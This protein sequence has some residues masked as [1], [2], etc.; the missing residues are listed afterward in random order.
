MRYQQSRW[1]L[2]DLFPGPNSAELEAAF[3]TL[4][5]QV[6]ALEKR[7]PELTDDISLETFLSI[8]KELETN[9]ELAQKVYAFAG[10][11]FAEDT[12]NQVALNLMAKVEQ[13]V[14]E[15]GN[16]ILFFNLWW[17]DLPAEKAKQLIDG[18]GDYAYW[19][20]AMRLFIPH[21]LSEAE[22]KIINIKNVTGQSALQMVYSS[23]TNRYV[24]KLEVDG[25]VKELTR[26]ELM[27]YVRKADPEIRA[28]AYQELYKVYGDDSPILGQIYQT[29]VR[30]WYNEQVALRKHAS[31]IAARNLI[32]D[33]PDAVVNTLLDVCQKNASV[34]QSFFRLKAKLIG[35]DKLRRYDIYAPVVKSDKTYP[36]EVGS[37]LVL[38]AYQAFDPKFAE[39]AERVFAQKHLDSEVRKGK[40]GGAFC[41][42]SGPDLTP[43]V[44]LNYQAKADDVSTMAHELG[45]A[46]HGMLAADHS[47]F[48]FHSNLPLAE[49]ASTFG[50]MVLV[51]HLL[52]HETDENVRRDILFG[53]ID[54]AYGTIMRQAF[55]A[56]FERKAHQMIQKGASVDDLAEAYLQNLKSQ[57][58][59]AVEVS[60]EFRWEWVSIPH[61]YDVPFYVYAYTFGQLLVLSLYQ[62]YKREGQSFIPRYTKIL[63]TGGSKAPVKVLSEAGI[64]VYDAS[65]WQGGFDVLKGLISELEAL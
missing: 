2:D 30:D 53:Q 58:G 62:Q 43:W 17:K 24:F 45:H 22:E 6:V 44:M 23:I 19:L 8:I 27:M 63:A 13:F 42:P 21:T 46:I 48:T 31:P 52:K 55:F 11:Y 29:L 4:G 59:D 7:R 39:L 61:I 28:K 37:K 60:D 57:F 47:I 10:L 35:V 36:F 51:D 26:G 40:R 49:T 34:F 64:D 32:N 1:S 54:G 14:A 50:E 9:A 5:D 12:Q 38:E 65:F 33:I 18:S 20:E 16:R 56:L 41:W 15:L 25:E 3:V